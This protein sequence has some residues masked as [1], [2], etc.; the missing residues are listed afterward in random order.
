M[1]FKLP[2]GKEIIPQGR[3]LAKN[4]IIRT[5]NGIIFYVI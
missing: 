3:E 2:G 1:I 5:S 4:L